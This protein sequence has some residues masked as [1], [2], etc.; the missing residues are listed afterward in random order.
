MAERTL[1]GDMSSDSISVAPMTKW[2]SCLG[3]I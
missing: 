1:A 2:W 3:A